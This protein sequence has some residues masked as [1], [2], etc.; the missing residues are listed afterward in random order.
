[1]FLKAAI[2]FFVIMF[3]ENQNVKLLFAFAKTVSVWQNSLVESA[4]QIAK[5]TLFNVLNVNCGSIANVWECL[6]QLLS[7][8]L[9]KRLVS[10]VVPVCLM[11]N[12]MTLGKPFKGIYLFTLQ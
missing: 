2:L 12:Y 1:M 9:L 7:L 3:L 5:M 11:G 6:H 8:G 4:K 10:S